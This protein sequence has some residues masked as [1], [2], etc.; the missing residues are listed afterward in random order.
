MGDEGIA[1]HMLSV[2]QVAFEQIQDPTVAVDAAIAALVVLIE[3]APEAG[4]ALLGGAARLIAH[5][6]TGRG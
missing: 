1:S 2:M 6:E 4:A 3:D 5:L